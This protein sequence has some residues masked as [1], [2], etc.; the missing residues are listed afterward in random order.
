[1][2][3]LGVTYE[4]LDFADVESGLRFFQGISKVFEVNSTP[5]V[6]VANRKQIKAKKLSGSDINKE[7]ILKTIHEM[8][9]K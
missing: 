5:T 4:P 2:A 3:P 6:V 7:T 8:Q 1:V 9:S